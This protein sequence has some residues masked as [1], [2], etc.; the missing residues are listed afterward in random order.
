MVSVSCPASF[1]FIV[2]LSICVMSLAT[3]LCD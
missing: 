2:M 3:D 1:G